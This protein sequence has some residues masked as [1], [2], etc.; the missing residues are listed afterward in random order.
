MVVVYSLLTDDLCGIHVAN[1][2]SVVEETVPFT[3]AGVDVDMATLDVVTEE[4]G[5]GNV[6]GV[7]GILKGGGWST[8][9]GVGEEEGGEWKVEP[10]R[11][12]GEREGGGREEGR[13]RGRGR[14]GE[15]RTE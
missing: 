11:K 13:E 14:E 4:V 3:V 10:G 9:T 1:G 15:G 2:S 5:I 6:H 7:E 8:L 12:D